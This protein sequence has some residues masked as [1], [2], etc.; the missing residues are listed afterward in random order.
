MV[1][2]GRTEEHLEMVAVKA[3]NNT[4]VVDGND[5]GVARIECLC[6]VFIQHYHLML[7][8]CPPGVIER[9]TAHVL[10]PYWL[11]SV[12]ICSLTSYVKTRW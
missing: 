2:G 1:H 11:S 9:Q 6:S 10:E 8:H 7:S 4:P 5:L 12:E 3:G